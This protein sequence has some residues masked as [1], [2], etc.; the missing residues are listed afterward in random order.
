MRRVLPV[1]VLLALLATSAAF[2]EDEPTPPKKEAGKQEA[3]KQRPRKEGPSL[4]TL[5]WAREVVGERLKQAEQAPEFAADRDWLNVSR[6]LTLA[7]DLKGKV[8]ILDF[9]CYCCINCLHVLP[10]LHY[11]EE[12]YADKPFAVVGVHSAKFENEKDAAQIRE[13]ILRYDIQ[14][15][16]VNDADFAIWRSYG[17]RSW[18]T[19]A[20]IAPDGT[21]I[22]V[23]S[24]EGRREE[25]DALVQALLER[26]G[27]LAPETLNTKALPMRLE[28]TTKPPGMLAYP[29]KVLAAPERDSLFIA[30]SGHNRVVEVA[31]DG[32]F[33]RA[34]GSG[35]AGLQDGAP[36]EARFR[37]PQGMAIHEGVLWVCDTGNHAIRRIDLETGNVTT[38]AGTGEKGN[39]WRLIQR[40]GVPNEHGPWPGRTTALSSPW[41]I[42]FLDGV[43][44][45]AMAGSHSMW[46]IDPKTNAVRHTAGDLT[47]RRLDAE[48]PYQ[49]A[50]A[51]PS[52]LA[53]DGTVLFIA[54]SESSAILQ[55]VP[56][57]AVTTLAGAEKDQPTNLFHFGDE[58]GVGWG[59]RFQHPLGVA[60][61]RGK[62][63]VA[64]SYNH[65]LKYVLVD[66]RK[67][68]S[69]LGGFG[70]PRQRDD[71]PPRFAE[72]SGLSIA[73]DRLYVAD[74][75][76][77]A[78]Q[79]ARLLGTDTGEVG[80]ISYPRALPLKGVP[81][82]AAHAKGGMGDAWPR[83]P[84]TVV[85][86]TVK[87]T[88]GVFEG[89]R[90]RLELTLPLGWKLSP[91]APSLLRLE[92]VTGGQATRRAHVDVPITGPTTELRLPAVP[93]SHAGRCRVR[94]LYYACSEAGT[95]RV[96]SL[97]IPLALEVAPDGKGEPGTVVL[98]DT[99]LP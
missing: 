38:A 65:K 99:F 59:R 44:H 27:Q 66:S 11:L 45:I 24:G 29:G 34:F 95:C 49:A 35:E 64:D 10:D 52:G 82:P 33:K 12:R 98:K 88:T 83:L 69:F 48:D 25:L 73:G 14:H 16:V 78:V 72:P 84:G 87:A 53:T 71:A 32:T 8:V 42:L 97:E 40:S 7:E 77:H 96:Q 1:L 93:S 4:G 39:H 85:R 22:G 56:G 61:H 68:H 23:L 92:Y 86:E 79:V 57:G 74:T 67:V 94:V 46:S 9:W 36:A 17:A 28:K 13:A 41:D 21:F 50:F 30:D 6:P 75:N 76:N 43:G 19:F 60:Y 5:V 3:G 91:D 18:P 58:D 89:T 54:D 80:G 2:A 47:E 62:L 37:G 70:S 55:A 20:V 26:F 81:I 90:L 51:Q 63:W 15:P 31:L